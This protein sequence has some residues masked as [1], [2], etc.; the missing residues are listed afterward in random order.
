M[1]GNGSLVTLL[2]VGDGGCHL[3]FILNGLISVAPLSSP[4]CRD[5][6]GLLLSIPVVSF[7]D[8]EGGGCL[9]ITSIEG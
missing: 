8:D 6:G 7:V 9:L 3:K 5:D 2:R 4:A 1:K